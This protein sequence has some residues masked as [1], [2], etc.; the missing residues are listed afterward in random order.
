[1]TD[2]Y[3]RTITKEEYLQ[4][5]A[6]LCMARKHVKIAGEYEAAYALVFTEKEYSQFNDDCFDERSLDSILRLRNI[7]VVE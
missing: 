3:K 6:L 4:A 1:M 7:K 2:E 5:M